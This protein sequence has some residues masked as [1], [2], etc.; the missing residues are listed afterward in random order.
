MKA[1]Q[2]HPLEPLGAG[3]PGPLHRTSRTWVFSSPA[4]L[5]RWDR[6]PSASRLQGE[7]GPSVPGCSGPFSQT[8]DSVGTLPPRRASPGRHLA[9]SSS[10]PTRAT[11]LPMPRA[12]S[13]QPFACCARRGPGKE[14]VGCS[15]TVTASRGCP[16]SMAAGWAGAGPHLCCCRYKFRLAG[17]RWPP[18]L[19]AGLA[20]R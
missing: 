13:S 9:F 2:K 5:R 16:G 15:A 11:T 14:G 8:R 20:S 18:L 12:L 17:G 19:G 1:R 10:P 6:L 4:R 7:E 3:S